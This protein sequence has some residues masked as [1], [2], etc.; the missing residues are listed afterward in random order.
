M[1]LTLVSLGCPRRNTKIQT[2]Q[3][4]LV[5]LFASWQH[6]ILIRLLKYRCFFS[7]INESVWIIHIYSVTALSQYNVLLV[8]PGIRGE[9]RCKYRQKL[10]IFARISGERFSIEKFLWWT[11]YSDRGFARAGNFRAII[12]LE[13]LVTYSEEF[14][15]T[16]SREYLVTKYGEKPEK[17]QPNL[18]KFF[19]ISRE[20]FRRT[21]SWEFP[22][23]YS[24][25]I[26]RVF[27]ATTRDKI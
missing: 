15:V 22:G 14:L 9:I 4:L 20:R 8:I 13:F 16:N 23:N 1:L 18:G 26:F 17:W 12:S 11:P 10:E 24:H 19:G 27:L 2:L 5:K 7:N 25:D 21:N 3:Q 6:K